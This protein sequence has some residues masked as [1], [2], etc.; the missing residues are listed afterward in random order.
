MLVFPIH[1]GLQWSSLLSSQLIVSCIR[2]QA[3]VKH[4][5]SVWQLFGTMLGRV[6]CGL[7]FFFKGLFYSI[8]A[9]LTFLTP[10]LYPS[11][12]SH[13]YH[14]VMGAQMS[15]FWSSWLGCGDC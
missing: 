7:C 6:L 10:S 12:F 14:S 11:F 8:S 1:L 4:A 3:H 5:V 2:A 9:F 15:L 13:C